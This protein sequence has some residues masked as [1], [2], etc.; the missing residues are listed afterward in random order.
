MPRRTS[1]LVRSWPWKKWPARWRQRRSAI[2]TAKTCC[3]MCRSPAI[4]LGPMGRRMLTL[5]TSR[6]SIYV[7]YSSSLPPPCSYLRQQRRVCGRL[8]AGRRRNGRAAWHVRRP[9][10]HVGRL[11][12]PWRWFPPRLAKQQRTNR[13]LVGWAARQPSSPSPYARGRRAGRAT[14]LGVDLA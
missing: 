11:L 12:V 5:Q 7:Y 2:T 3:S 14:R 6:I 4:S 10:E 1:Q 13:R 9:T 8:L